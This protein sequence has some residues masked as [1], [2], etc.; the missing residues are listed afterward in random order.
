MNSKVGAVLPQK[1]RKTCQDGK[2]EA[3]ERK[4][5]EK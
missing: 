4:N 5:G 2:L 3:V 1:S